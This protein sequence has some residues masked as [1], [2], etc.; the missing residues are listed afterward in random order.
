MEF[1]LTSNQ[2]QELKSLRKNKVK[3]FIN[4][5]L[6]LLAFTLCCFIAPIIVICALTE[7]DGSTWLSRNIKQIGVVLS[8]G[9]LYL[10]VIYYFFLGIIIKLNKD[11]KLRSGVIEKHELIRKQYFPLTKDLFFFFADPDISNLRVD[12]NT[13]NR[14]T[15]GDF[16]PIL[17]AKYS[18]VVLQDV[19][20]H[21]TN[22]D[23]EFEEIGQY[24]MLDFY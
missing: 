23:H 4:T 13:Y 5:L 12:V 20:R 18:K 8:F 21:E 17:R 24:G 14:F 2:L 7:S 1:I 22:L 11:I 19:E 9:A 3:L 15:E 16:Y 6:P 10:R